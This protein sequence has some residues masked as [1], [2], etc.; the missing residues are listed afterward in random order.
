[1]PRYSVYSILCV[2]LCGTL[3]LTGCGA[4]PPAASGESDPAATTT[5]FTVSSKSADSTTETQTSLSAEST[6]ESATAVGTTADSAKT[7]TAPGTTTAQDTASTTLPPAPPPTTEAPMPIGERQNAQYKYE[8]YTD[9][10]RITRY[11]GSNASVT[12]PEKLDGLPVRVIGAC[13]FGGYRNT[14]LQEVTL[15]DSIQH[16]ET[17]AFSEC[18]SLREV[19]FP[20]HALQVDYFAFEETPWYEG[21]TEEFAIVSG[22]LLKYNG[23]A[24]TVVVPSGVRSLAGKFIPQSTSVNTIVVPESVTTLGIGAFAGVSVRKVVLSAGIKALPAFAFSSCPVLQEVTLPDTLESIGEFAFR[25]CSL[26]KLKIPNSVRLIGKQPFY[27]SAIAPQIP[28]GASGWETAYYGSGITAFHLPD[29]ATVIPQECFRECGYLKSVTIPS[30]IQT[31]GIGA[32]TNCQQLET[33]V[34]EPG[35]KAIQNG[36]FLGCINLKDVTI[37]ETVTNITGM[38]I[39][40]DCP[41]SLRIHGKAGSAAEQYAKKQGF[42]FVAE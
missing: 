33:V 28:N 27:G 31:I 20:S 23:T 29:H 6:S 14:T 34:I 1:M 39:F 36:A 38:Q 7:T 42:T 4:Q 8:V 32:F 11:L 40:Q 13:S 5:A 26:T 2:L 9:Y 21:L 30:R 3:L 12:I 25:D 17:E 35:V 37:P 22:I 41:K 24:D 19:H 15:P 16:I 10:V 18:T